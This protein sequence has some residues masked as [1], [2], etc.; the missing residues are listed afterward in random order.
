M[1]TQDFKPPFSLGKLFEHKYIGKTDTYLVPT[2]ADSRHRK[3]TSNVSSC[4]ENT[5]HKSI[6]KNNSELHKIT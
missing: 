2:Q 5:K 4:D 1:T 3:Y 6:I